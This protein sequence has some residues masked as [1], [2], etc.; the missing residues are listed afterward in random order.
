MA[1]H[2]DSRGSGANAT[3]KQR[4]GWVLAKRGFQR[5]S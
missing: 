3:L 1:D 4:F 5:L 2:A